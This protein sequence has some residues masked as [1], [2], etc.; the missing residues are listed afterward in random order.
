[1]AFVLPD[2]TGPS[3][4]SGVTGTP[5]TLIGFSATESTGSAAAKFRLH[6]GGS[7]SAPPL[8]S[9]QELAA[10]T[11]NTVVY[12]VGVEI[13][14]GEVWLEIISGSVEIEVYW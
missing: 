6:D 8:D 7:S 2:S 12:P 1:M 11:N 10:G 4:P 14:S 9:E 5:D 13:V 3:F